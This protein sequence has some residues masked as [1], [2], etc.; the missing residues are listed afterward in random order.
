MENL[1][2]DLWPVFLEETAA[3]FG[4][5]DHIRYDRKVTGMNWNS[6][7][8]YWQLT[9][10]SKEGE[11][12]R[13]TANFI[14]SAAGYYNYDK[15]HDPHFEGRDDFSGDIVHPQHWPDNYDVSGKKIA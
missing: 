13:L 11:T 3:E 8:A 9:L 4:I 15:G 5:E 10:T 12:F 6:D 2:T 7:Q 1:T 14:I